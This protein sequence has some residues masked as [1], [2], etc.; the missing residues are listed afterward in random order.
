MDQNKQEP[1]ETIDDFQNNITDNESVLSNIDTTPKLD[2]FGTAQEM[3]DR[4]PVTDDNGN[5]DNGI[6]NSPSEG[7]SS[8]TETNEI[9]KIYRPP[10]SE[11]I[12][13]K[14][15]YYPQ[16]DDEVAYFRQGHEYYLN[17]VRQNNIYQN[18][19]AKPWSRL[20]LRDY[21]FLKVI[22]IKYETRPPR[23]C[24]LK[25]ALMNNDGTLKNQRFTIKYHD[26]PGVLDFLVLKQTYV[27]ALIHMWAT[28]D[29]FR[30]MID[31][32]WWMGQIISR[33]PYSE[34]FP[35]SLFMCFKI[36]WDSGKLQRMSPWDMEPIDNSRLPN[37]VGGGVPVLAEELKM[38]LYQPSGDR[39][40]ICCRILAALE[41]VMRLEIAKP[42]LTPVDLNI[43]PTYAFIVEYPIDLTTIKARFENRFYRRIAAAQFDIRYLATNAE[44]FYK[45]DN[46]IVQNARIITDLCLRI[47]EYPDLDVNAIYHQLM[48]SYKTEVIDTLKGET[49]STST[50]R[51]M[52]ARQLNHAPNGVT[53]S[54]MKTA[55]VVIAINDLPKRDQDED[56]SVQSTVTESQT[57]NRPSGY[58]TR[59]SG[60]SQ[61]TKERSIRSCRSR[62]RPHYNEDSEEDDSERTKRHV[63]QGRSG[64][65][66]PQCTVNKVCFEDYTSNND[67]DEEAEQQISI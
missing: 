52:R 5:D 60:V 13:R 49:P 33:V 26:M 51:P 44:R 36:R 23:L 22:E 32:V 66:K 42:F 59:D 46:H 10:K 64:N 29:R 41:D 40:G 58:S 31:N 48:A 63:T 11:V 19:D 30:C 20:D 35:D 62:K 1:S 43:Y 17:A 15:P 47:L 53:S 14:T 18:V 55:Q 38:I 67:G 57:L 21:E 28:G 37:E 9:P 39:D 12:P 3:D 45:S 8:E 25:V 65:R 34:E 24:C 7:P 16:I 56:N 27:K 54:Q 50:D 4:I 61:R 2:D 6:A